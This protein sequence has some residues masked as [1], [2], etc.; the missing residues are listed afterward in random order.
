MMGSISSGGVPRGVIAPNNPCFW[1][2]TRARRNFR[3]M[4]AGYH[5]DLSAK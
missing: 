1:P 2:E 5:R 4:A 3:V